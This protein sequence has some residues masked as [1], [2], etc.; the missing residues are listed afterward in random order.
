MKNK[1]N[2]FFEN[3]KIYLENNKKQIIINYIIF[4]ALLF[5]LLLI[6]LLTKQ[7]IFEWSS[8]GKKGN[9]RIQFEC[10]FIGIKSI[11]NDGLTVFL[12]I[13]P[14]PV[15]HFLNFIIL[16]VCLGFLVFL[17]SPSFVV[18]VTFICAGTLGN[19]IDRFLF[20]S[21]RDIIY[22]PWIN[23]GDNV[24]VFNLADVD[25]GI[26]AII[27]VVSLIVYIIKDAVKSR[28]NR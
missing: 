13:L 22:L 15:I 28:K 17:K 11:S 20:N 27:A 10:P 8:D 14:I 24:S 19:M 5:V 26:G 21:V 25:A 7:F 3:I 12:N 1:I 16:F 23:R 18:A 2:A 4:G 9:G 6:D